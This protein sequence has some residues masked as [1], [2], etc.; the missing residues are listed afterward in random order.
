MYEL[1]RYERD[2]PPSTV[3][4][5]EMN[6]E[7]SRRILTATFVVLTYT[8]AHKKRSSTIFA[9]TSPS[10]ECPPRSASNAGIERMFRQLARMTEA[11]RGMGEDTFHIY[12]RGDIG[13][14]P[15]KALREAQDQLHSGHAGRIQQA[16]VK[17]VIE[18]TAEWH[19]QVKTDEKISKKEKDAGIG[20]SI[21][22]LVKE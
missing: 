7:L 13:F 1:Y 22:M 6:N 3:I 5:A 4:P 9:P 8:R 14:K 15:A 2:L 16:F 11:A 17:G 20:A 10:L 21:A 19:R 12:T 18:P